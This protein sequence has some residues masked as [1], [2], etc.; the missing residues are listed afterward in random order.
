[1]STKSKPEPTPTLPH[2]SEKQGYDILD[3]IAGILANRGVAT[4]DE[5]ERA[6]ENKFG[7]DCLY[8]RFVGPMIDEIEAELGLES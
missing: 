6:I 7:A 8:D 2:P 1:M 3:Q 4:I 5:I